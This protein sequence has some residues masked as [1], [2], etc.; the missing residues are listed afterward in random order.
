MLFFNFIL[1]ILNF[2]SFFLF[3]FVLKSPGFKLSIDAIYEIIQ[4]EPIPIK[5]EEL[6]CPPYENFVN[7]K[8][9]VQ[10]IPNS[11]LISYYTIDLSL[12]EPSVKCVQFFYNNKKM[13]SQTLN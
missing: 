7:Q 8:S 9:I 4:T 13:Q 2:T 3:P 12:N 6:F 10:S 11:S 1:I 5:N